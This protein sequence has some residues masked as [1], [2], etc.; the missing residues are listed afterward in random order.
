MRIVIWR[1]GSS[2]GRYVFQ[3]ECEYPLAD[4]GKMLLFFGEDIRLKTAKIYPIF[5]GF[6]IQTLFAIPNLHHGAGFRLTNGGQGM[7]YELAGNINRLNQAY[8][9]SGFHI[10]KSQYTVSY[11]GE[12]TGN[13]M[14]S[15]VLIPAVFGYRKILFDS[16]LA[17]TMRPYWFGELGQVGQLTGNKLKNLRLNGWSSEWST[18]IGLQFRAGRLIHRIHAGYTSNTFIDG[19]AVLGITFFWK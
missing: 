2:L 12:F 4:Y 13:S 11:Y 6:I 19:N 18:G 15:D 5:I 14:N 3:S 7:Y 16:K 17:G 9:N 8:F 10:E 1:T